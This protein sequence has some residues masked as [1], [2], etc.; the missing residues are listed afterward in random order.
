MTKY[1]YSRKNF[2]DLFTNAVMASRLSGNYVINPDTFHKMREI[3]L[4]KA[5]VK[6]KKVK[7]IEL[8]HNLDHWFGDVTDALNGLLKNK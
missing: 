7:K 6:E 3:L 8:P 5:P 1:K 4:A 2:W